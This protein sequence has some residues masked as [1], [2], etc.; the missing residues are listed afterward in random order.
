MRMQLKLQG[1]YSKRIKKVIDRK[2]SEFID[3]YRKDGTIGK[4]ELW[5]DDLLE[6][7]KSMYTE[8]VITFANWQYRRLRAYV[9]K[10]MMGYNAQ[11]TQEVN[12]YLATYGLDLVSTVSGRFRERI[13]AII[14]NEIQNGVTEGLGIEVVKDNILRALQDTRT[15]YWAE[16]IARTETMRAA[17]IGH[18]KGADAHGFYVVKEWIA[19]KDHRTRRMP[20]DEFDHWIL[21]GQKREMNEVFYQMG[22]TGQI[23]NAMQPGD[24]PAAFTINCRC[25]IGFEPKRDSNGRLIRKV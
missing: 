17:N 23:A 12:E 25:T 16:R 22:K 8:S 4:F 11:W 5:N 20:D 18:M 15:D 14:N 2:L 21:D 7:Y 1:K 19:A 13:L 6:V 10:Q 9:I 24:G 3:N